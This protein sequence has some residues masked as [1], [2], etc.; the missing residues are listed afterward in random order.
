MFTTLSRYRYLLKNGQEIARYN[1]LAKAEEV[2]AG[3]VAAVAAR[4]VKTQCYCPYWP[5]SRLLARPEI[6]Y[7]SAKRSSAEQAPNQ[8]ACTVV[9]VRSVLAGSRRLLLVLP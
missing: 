1:E 3:Y 8:N 4:C 6:F 7:L 9:R 5:S 2:R